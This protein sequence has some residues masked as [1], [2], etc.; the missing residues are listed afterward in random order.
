MD[1]QKEDEQKQP[2]KPNDWHSISKKGILAGKFLLL[3]CLCC[4][5]A[6]ATINYLPKPYAYF[7]L[8]IEIALTIIAVGTLVRMSTF[9]PAKP[10]DFEKL[11]SQTELANLLL[12][13]LNYDINRYEEG[14]SYYFN[15]VRFYKYST[16]LLAGISTIILGLD[17]GDIGNIEVID[18]MKYTTFA[19]NV[20]LI[21]GAIITISTS[22]V[23]YWNIEKYWLTNKTIVNKLRA[24]RDDVESEYV[25]ETLDDARLKEKIDEYKKIKGDFYKYWEG[26]LADRGTQSG[27]GNSR[28][29]GV[30]SGG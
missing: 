10:Y 1:K 2:E 3:F 24:L 9:K 13:N 11:K 4:L 5:L 15:G 28:N 25:G 27:Q 26:A 7:V 30:M 20:A 14:S 19:K 12:V 6:V 16:I 18:K 17:L 29:G 22:L 23:T 21:I 8:G